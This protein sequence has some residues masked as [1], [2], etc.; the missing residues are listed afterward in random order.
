MF[1]LQ[2]ISVKLPLIYSPVDGP[3]QL[4]K[5]LGEVVQQ[6]FKNL[7]LTSPGERVMIPDFGVGLRRMLFEGF[8]AALHEQIST[9]INIQT[10]KYLP[11]I[12]IE[13]IHFR[14]NADNAD[15]GLNELE[16]S[17]VYNMGSLDTRSTLTIT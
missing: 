9:A 17:V 5:T 3:Y 12:N 4:N 15:L 7:L 8:S 1:G 14:T 6:N 13:G 16:I 10:N 11:F 2:G